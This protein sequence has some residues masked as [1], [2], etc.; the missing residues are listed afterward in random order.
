[1]N[2]PPG[3]PGYE[4]Y[5]ATEVLIARFGSEKAAKAALGAT[6]KKAKRVANHPRHIPENAGEPVEG[7]ALALAAEAVRAYERYLLR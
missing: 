1:V 7:D 2:T 3:E 5:K 6:V 4:A